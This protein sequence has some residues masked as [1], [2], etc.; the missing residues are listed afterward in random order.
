MTYSIN[1]FWEYFINISCLLTYMISN[2]LSIYPKFRVTLDWKAQ[3]LVKYYG[4][5]KEEN[6]A[7]KGKD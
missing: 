1:F 4:L 6:K 2:I 7:I 3:T 5:R